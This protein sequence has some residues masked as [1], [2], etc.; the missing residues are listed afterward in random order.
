MKHFVA[1]VALLSLAVFVVAGNAAKPELSS[2][3]AAS[4]RVVVPTSGGSVPSPLPTAKPPKAPAPLETKEHAA[5]AKAIVAAKP[6]DAPPAPAARVASTMTPG[7]LEGAAGVNALLVK[8]TW[9]YSDNALFIA[10]GGGAVTIRGFRDGMWMVDCRVEAAGELTVSM[11]SH[12]YSKTY[13]LV[14]SGTLKTAAVD[15]HLV[16]GMYAKG[17]T[18]TNTHVVNYATLTFPG[19]WFWFDCTLTPV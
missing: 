5:F 14:S 9:V 18:E 3:K 15:G 17:G 16:F 10:D 6:N 13:S 11:M 19:K 2:K 12:D 4:V 8:P 7:K 1:A